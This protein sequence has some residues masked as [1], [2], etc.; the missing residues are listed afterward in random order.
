VKLHFKTI[1][2]IK[3]LT[4]K[5]AHDL[6]SDP[7]YAARDLVNTLDSGKTVEW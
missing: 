1:Q 4:G 7:D 5:E 6:F 2:G 3:N